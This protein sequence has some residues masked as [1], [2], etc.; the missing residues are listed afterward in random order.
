M[1]D[2]SFATHILGYPRIG[3]KRALKFALEQYWAGDLEQSALLAQAEQIE[4]A[5]WMAQVAA[6]L[7]IITVGDF[8]LYDAMLTLYVRLGLL[9]QRFEI[10]NVLN[11]VD[12]QFYL[13]RGKTQNEA[14]PSVAALEMTKWFD[15]NYHYLVPELADQE[16]FARADFSSLVATVKRAQAVTD[17]PLKVA[18]IGPLTFLYL[19][20][21]QQVDTLTLLPALLVVYARLLSDLQ[22]TGATWI[23]I[24]EPILALDLPSAWLQAFERTYHQLSSVANN[25]ILTTYFGTPNHQIGTLVSLPVRG[26]HLDLTREPHPE[27]ALAQWL[28]R[29]SPKR[30]VSLGLVD[31]RQVWKTKFEQQQALAQITARYDAE[32]RWIGTSCSLLHV[33]LDLSVETVP[34]A[35]Q[36]QLAFARQKLDEVKQLA[37]WQNATTTAISHDQDMLQTSIQYQQRTASFQ[38]RYPAQ[39]NQLNLPLYPTTTIG[40]FPQTATIRTKRADWKAGR[41]S[42]E[43]YVEAMQAEIQHVIAAQETLGL[44]VFVHGEPERS[45]MVEYFAEQLDGV[46]VT[47]HG[48]VQSYGSRCVRP[49]I[50]YHTISRPNPMTVSWTT[51]AQNQTVKPVKG[52]LTGPV[53]LLNWS[54]APRGAAFGSARAL[55]AAQLADVVRQEVADLQAAGISIIQIDEPAFREG[56]PL[57]QQDQPGYWSWAVKSFIHATSSAKPATQIHTHMCYSQFTD[58]LPQIVQMDAD[59]ITIETSRSGLQLLDV[60]K[61]QGYPNAIGPG[62]YDIHSPNVPQTESMRYVIETAQRAIPVERL[63]I[64][65]DCGLKTRH[66]PEVMA[67]LDA[68]VK[69]ATNLRENQPVI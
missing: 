16:D 36:N 55:V 49:P 35:L 31:G 45:D 59:V 21:R 18:L 69:T 42:H 61:Q 62:V 51:F 17:R 3:E 54:F 8:V 32:A 12:R 44:D 66:W 46:W 33:P 38:E 57:R 60:F 9:P 43:S 23:Q 27:T 25:L 6:G 48:W 37:Q 50:I 52:M 29:L 15:T 65:P 41:L 5:G 1:S 63:W 53:T 13:A 64:N 14:L 19:A 47:Q 28:D 40:S 10:A 20:R 39:R 26:W 7:D 56:L 22:A 2:L 11:E 67:A 68:M 4:Q 58:C 24:E 34:V 30:I